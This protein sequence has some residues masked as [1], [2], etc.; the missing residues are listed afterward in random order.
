MKEL[1]QENGKKSMNDWMN[2]RKK[3]KNKNERKK[4]IKAK[5]QALYF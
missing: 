3:S 1:K 2:E 4:T 5:N